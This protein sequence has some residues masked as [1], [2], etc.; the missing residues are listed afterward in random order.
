VD[1]EILDILACPW[2]TTRPVPG[3]PKLAKARL[4]AQGPAERP[5]GLKCPECNRVYAMLEGELPNLL[6][7]EAR[8]ETNP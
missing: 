2:C 3:T 8:I 5:T 6:V 7:E 4:L 1:A